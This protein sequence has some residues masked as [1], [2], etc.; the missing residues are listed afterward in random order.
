MRLS[1]SLFYSWGT[2]FRPRVCAL[3][4]PRFRLWSIGQF[5]IP[6]RPCRGFWGVPFYLQLQPTS[7]PSFI[8]DLH[9]DFVCLVWCSGGC[10]FQ[11]KESLCF[12]PIVAAPDSSWQFVVEVDASEVG[13]QFFPS[14]APGTDRCILVRFIPIVYPPQNGITTLAT[15][16][17]WQSSWPLRNVVTG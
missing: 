17:C 3:I 8:F 10:F 2:S 4:P 16:S 11:S 15:G 12:D 1:C 9:Q 6:T 14:S 13:V 5:R 7:H